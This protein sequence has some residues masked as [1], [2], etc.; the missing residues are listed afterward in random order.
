MSEG[1]AGAVDKRF[2]LPIAAVKPGAGGT[3]GE[4][5]GDIQQRILSVTLTRPVR[6]HQPCRNGKTKG[7]VIQALTSDYD[8]R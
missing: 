2:R 5:S 7:A 6:S 8:K 3:F 1:H 4:D